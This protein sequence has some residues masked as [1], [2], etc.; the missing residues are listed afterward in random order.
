MR[1]VLLA[2][3]AIASLWLTTPAAAND[4][5]PDLALFGALPSIEDV[6]ISPD[7]SKL[8]VIT[9]D[10]EQR[11]LTIRK[12]EGGGLAG[13]AVGDKKLRSVT[14][15]GE[16][17]VIL[18][19]SVASKGESFT[20]PAREYFLASNFNVKANV[21][22]PLL[23]GVKDSLNIVVGPP[24]VRMIK[25]DPIVFLEGVH[26]MRGV[27]TDTLFRLN[28]R[29]NALK[30]LDNGV[31]Y[32]TDGWLVDA[33]GEPV[34]QSMYD[35]QAGRWSLLMKVGSTWKTIDK[36]DAPMGSYGLAGF[37]RDGKSVLVRRGYGEDALREYRT[38]GQ[39]ETLPDDMAFDG[40]LHD[41]QTLKLVGGYRLGR[42]EIVYNFF[43]AALQSAWWSVV[44]PFKDARVTLHSASKDWRRMVVRVD[45]PVDGPSFALVDLNTRR[46]WV[47]GPAYKGIDAKTVSPV[48][49]I[50]YT[51]ADGLPITGYLTMPRGREA[52]NL[53]LIVLPHGG[54]EG[55]ATPGYDWWSQALASRGYAVLQPNFRGSQGFGED[56]IKAGFGEWGRKMQTD[57]SDGVH[58]L[59]RQ[60]IVDPKR[61]CIM[62]ASYGGY[63]ALA[64]ATLDRGTYRCAVSV[65][66]P[67][68]LNVV[69]RTV[70]RPGRICM[71]ADRP[72]ENAQAPGTAG[73]TSGGIVKLDTYECA[74]EGTGPS[75][76]GRMLAI[77]EDAPRRTT[78]MRYWLRF[79]GD[80]RKPADLKAISPAQQAD[81]ADIPIL[82]IHGQDDTIVP[83]EQ[84]QAMADA[85]KKAGK[86]VALVPL[87]GEDHWLSRG[88]TRLQMLTEAVA[89]VE[90]YNPPS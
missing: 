32:G 71:R 10:G 79:M 7:G 18:V 74:R 31:R 23:S 47:L 52:R 50:T 38:D 88:T 70:L 9:T 19:S 57:L 63:A 55:R 34:A 21:Q 2:V 65:A 17:N 40:L 26:M 73:T 14:W 89:F 33:A 12:T 29:T 82:L 86:P 84:S 69:R 48:Q 43:D 20:G 85:L 83:F 15:A 66:G 51:A 39:H 90:K 30:M 4:D 49:T 67:S 13:I 87:K 8:A 5:R 6:Q 37:G 46:G 24:Q 3:G 77:D 42:D 35:A 60:G 16:N 11:F 1:K 75:N 56:F 36:T 54:P 61:V 64:G 72:G 78:S 62:G 22:K 81:K 80:D 45:S 41:P 28:L 27:G 53:P 59:A 58:D 68:D 76:P 44:K 25:G